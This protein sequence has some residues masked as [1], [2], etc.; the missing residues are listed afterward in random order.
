MNKVSP[1]EVKTLASKFYAEIK[2]T[3]EH[4]HKHPELSFN[5][6]KTADFV[7]QFLKKIQVDKVYRLANTGVIAEIGDLS[8][9]CIALR[10]DLDALP[11][12][13]KN[14]VAYKSVNQGVMHACGHDVHTA[15]LLGVAKILVQLKSKLTKGYRLIFQPGEEKLPGGASLLIKEGVLTN[16]K[17]E[18]IFGQHVFPDLPA[19]KVGFRQG[20]Y[21]ASC[22][23]VYITIVGKGGHGAMPHKLIDPVLAASA[24]IVNLQQVASRR[25]NTNT[26]TVLSFGKVMAN[27]ATN[28]IPDEVSLAGTFRTFD[29]KWRAEAHNLIKQIAESTAAAY[30]AQVIVDIQKGYP[31][32]I[33]NEVLTAKAKLLA[34]ELLGSENVVELPMRPTGEDF[35]FYTHHTPGC[36]YR[37]GTNNAQNQFGNAVHNAKFDI[38]PTS[39][40]T[41]MALMAWLALNS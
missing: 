39:L 34:I 41:G 1:N 38:E 21:M 9:G 3:R 35:S 6:V 19:G 27:G 23:E 22:D 36:F 15:S 13:E 16:P 33:N 8:K 18:S 17:P 20:M 7:E 14:E 26:P 40:E 32:L 29:E 31:C 11:I 37:L 25:S 4:L 28:V 2:E 12:L 24:L 5:E 10:A 30:G